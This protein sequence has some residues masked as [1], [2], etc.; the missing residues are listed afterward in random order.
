MIR[1][2]VMDRERF[3]SQMKFLIEADR[4]KNILR[5]TLIADGSRRENDA[6]HSWHLALMAMTLSEYAAED[7][8]ISR[9]IQMAL[10]HDIVEIYAG[11]TFAY[12]AKG[13]ES[14]A[15]READAADRIFA[16][17]PEEQGR[18]Y[19][20]LWEE[21]DAM[22]TPD[23]R[24]AAAIDRLQPLVNNYLTDGHTWRLGGVTSDKVYKRIAPAEKA[25]PEVWP[26]ICE[27]IE[28]AIDKGMLKR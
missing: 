27:Y 19:R 13:N 16:M 7:I 4:M 22:E 25:M 5:M 28:K 18:E 6:E 9:V 17:L 3:E 14:K 12:D 8:D 24:Y 26:V 23:S 1:E 10:L 21:F 11:D 15:Q 20:A 2:I